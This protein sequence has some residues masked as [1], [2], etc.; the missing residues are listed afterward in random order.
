MIPSPVLIAFV[1]LV[2][3]A[4]GLATLRLFLGPRATDRI[5]ALDI[6]F[7]AAVALAIGRALALGRHEFLDIGI[8]LS[9]VGFVG[10]MAWARLVE[11]SSP[12]GKDPR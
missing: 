7:A 3:L 5:V 9:L 2:A 6:V 12:G 8:G 10:T 1:G 11:T 4:I